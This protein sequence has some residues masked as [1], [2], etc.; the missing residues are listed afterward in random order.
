MEWALFVLNK[1]H[2]VCLSLKKKRFGL[3]AR[4]NKALTMR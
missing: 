2:H 4:V 1:H 3:Y